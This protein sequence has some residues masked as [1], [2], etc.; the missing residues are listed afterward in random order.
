MRSITL[1]TP[2][3]TFLLD[4]RMFPN[5]GIL[6]VAGSLERAG[7]NVN[8][9]DLSGYKNFAKIAAEYADSCVSGLYGI[10]ATSPQ[11]PATVEIASAIR[12]ANPQ[13]RIILGG[14]HPTLV[15]AAKHNE[16]KQKRVGR[17]HRAADR[18]EQLFD[19]C[20]AGDGENAIFLA[21][22]ADS[23]SV[24]NADGFKDAQGKRPELFLTPAQLEASAF[25]ARHLIDLES[26]DFKIDGV[27]ASSIIAQLGC[28]FE[29]GFCAGRNSPTLRH[30]RTRGTE[31][32]VEEMVHM[33][34]NFGIRG[35]MFYDDEQNLIH[36]E[37]IE[38]LEAII[39]AQ[40]DLGV[41][42][43]LRGNVKSQLFNEA[44]AEAMYEAGYRKVLIGF[45]SGSPRIL[46]NIRK[47]AT[48]EEN[49]RC[50]EYAHK[51]HLEVKALMSI[52]HPGESTETINESRKW[53]FD[54]KPSEADFT[55]ITPYPGSPYYDDALP[56]GETR[57]GRETFVYTCRDKYNGKEI[58]DRLY[59]V[60]LDYVT[61]SDYY[62]G[63]PNAL[64][65]SHVWT[66]HLSPEELV[67]E[68]NQLETEIRGKLGIAYHR[69]NAPIDAEAVNYG[70]SMGQTPI[71]PS[72]MLRTS[73]P[74][75]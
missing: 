34:Q 27:R 1:I 70:H 11:L 40:R 9:L 58:P 33:Y 42:W 49:T 38:L 31:A 35:F 2:P 6:K 67:A 47:R 73:S 39:K 14:P 44:Q 43:R 63:D 50:L 8:H 29:C 71:L 66:D 22:E 28:P 53:L 23:P 59:Q 26:Y 7:W 41:E 45:E 62:K 13:A 51:Y 64:V 3:S 60:E 32:I 5:L 4:E 36:K 46:H 54:T 61:E 48:Q 15:Y 56:T 75:P 25:P 10:T 19:V 68:R 18:L 30:I 16:Q 57:E 37:F 69:R 20:V 65:I 55:I 72:R 74:Q 52:G 17:A 21:C 24:I 12:S